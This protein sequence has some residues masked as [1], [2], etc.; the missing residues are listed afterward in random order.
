VQSPVS[1]DPLAIG[2]AVSRASLGALRRPWRAMAA[3][4]RA[5][6]GGDD[7][8]FDDPAWRENPV[9]AALRRLYLSWAQMLAA[10]PDAARLE[11]KERARASF[12]LGLV[13]DALAPTNFLWTNPRALKRAFETGG[14]S[15][16]RGMRNMLRDVA[17]NGGLP[18]QADTSAFEIGR[19][20]AATPGRV[21]FRND[22]VELI[23]YAPQTADVFDVP[24]LCVPPWINK[25]YLLDLTPGRSVV[26]WCVQHGHT[27]FVLSYRNPDASSARVTMDDY[28]RLGPLAALDVI[29]DVT[30]S[31]A[32][33]VLGVCLGGLLTGL[34]AAYGDDRVGAVTLV[35][36]LLDYTDTGILGC[37]LDE[38]TVSRVEAHMSRRGFLGADEMTRTF[39]L[40][41]PNELVY[42]YVVSGWL[43]GEDPPAFDILAWGADGTRMPAAMHSRYLRDLYLNNK[44][45]R[46]E[47]E[48]AG[49][50]LDPSLAKQ[51]AYVVGAVRDHIVPWRSAYSSA[52]LLGGDVRFV[53]SSSGHV[54]GIVNPP[55]PRARMWVEGA[56]GDEPDRWLE[57]AWQRNASW[58]ED[59]A[60][61]LANRA[62]GLRRPPPMGSA[63]FPAIEEAPGVYVR[64]R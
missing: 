58:W 27:V 6:D 38:S 21:V 64:Q 18:R 48:V 56:F 12:G 5:P 4:L 53:L 24:L 20:M 7:G 23:Q 61:W 55:S 39:T 17:R 30:G 51:D 19:S 16:L 37:L 25:F 52:R 8:R 9:F 49:R 32:V 34:L 42:S 13:A 45:A 1:A 10:M 31:P 62:G 22:L 33:N 60:G 14:A 40:L 2:A 41:R 36:T 54:A 50:R 3:A 15:V 47:L 35:N 44:L 11:D 43:M 26:E 46:G 63:R 59:W 29:E 28:L 57:T